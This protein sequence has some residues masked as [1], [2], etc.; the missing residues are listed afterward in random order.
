MQATYIADREGNV[1][2]F[3][4]KFNSQ[5]KEKWMRDV[6]VSGQLA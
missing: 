3:S 4:I 2:S 6:P 1:L 5:Q